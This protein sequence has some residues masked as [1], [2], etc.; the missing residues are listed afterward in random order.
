[1]RSN[2]H[3]DKLSWLLLVWLQLVSEQCFLIVELEFVDKNTAQ[4][5]PLFFAKERIFCYLFHRV[6]EHFFILWMQL[7]GNP[8][9]GCSR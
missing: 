7:F 4:V 5:A 9:K 3:Q 8:V 6:I 1:M 2:S